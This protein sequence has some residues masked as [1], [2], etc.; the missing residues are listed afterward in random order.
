MLYQDTTNK[1]NEYDMKKDIS[2]MAKER[3]DNIAKPIDSLGLLE[4]YVVK[5]CNIS[6]SDQPYIMDKKALVIMCGDHGVVSEGVTQTGSHVTRIVSEN[7]AKGKS[8]VNQMA[9][10]AGADVFTIDMGMAGESYLEERLTTGAVINRKVSSGTKNMLYEPAMTKEECEKAINIGM[11]LV[12]ELKN[13]GYK[14]IATG[15]MG[16]GNT[17]STSV[18]TGILLDLEADKVVGRGAGLSDEG[19][20]KKLSVVEKTMERI[21]NKNI[22]KP[23]DLL[24]EAGGYELAG[25]TGLFLGGVKYHVP[26][27]IDGAISGVSA[28]VA[29]RIDSRVKDYALASH[30][31][32]EITGRLILEKLELEAIINGRLRLGEGSGAVALFP[33]LDMAMSVYKNMGSFK[34]YKIEAYK[35]F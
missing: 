17:T 34:E 6:G 19:M 4:N 33:L 13:M 23:I 5:L 22:T 3:W 29:S 9:K 10:E 12:A 25:M 20:T 14:I 30:V 28:L 24:A 21:K 7:F 27:V 11:D 26:I 2:K 16:I 31:S 1:E 32:D 8:C 15:E 35:R 18:L